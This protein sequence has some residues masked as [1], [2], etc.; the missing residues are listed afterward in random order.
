MSY[1]FRHTKNA[2]YWQT[3]RKG[4]TS[5]NFRAFISKHLGNYFPFAN[6]PIC[7]L[8]T[9][10]QYPAAHIFLQ[11]FHKSSWEYFKVQLSVKLLEVSKSISRHKRSQSLKPGVMDISVMFECKKFTFYFVSCY[12]YI[13]LSIKQSLD[14]L[15]RCENH[16]ILQFALQW[17]LSSMEIQDSIAYSFD[18]KLNNSLFNNKLIK[19]L[20]S[21]KIL[22]S[23]FAPNPGKLRL[24][25]SLSQ[26]SGP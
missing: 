26:Q 20:D 12:K 9:N 3:E 11:L 1:N 17:K 16:P 25:I 23:R 22:I 14:G 6:V 13:F 24:L 18:C 8:L 15:N 2:Y 4:T 5:E 10:A 7:L 19:N 21:S